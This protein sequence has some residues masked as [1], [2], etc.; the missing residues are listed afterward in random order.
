MS[1][2]LLVQIDRLEKACHAALRNSEDADT[3]SFLMR[4]L[5]C[6]KFEVAAKQRPLIR[7]YANLTTAHA[8]LLLHS[9][10]TSA[11]PAVIHSG[12]L[13]LCDSL[14]EFREIVAKELEPHG[15]QRGA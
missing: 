2:D 5:N 1:T 4:I 15:P 13:R 8:D 6:L 10:S 11:P 9:L 7:G 14:A 3:I 12:L